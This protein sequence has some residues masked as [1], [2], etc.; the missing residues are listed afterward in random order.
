[1]LSDPLIPSYAVG[2]GNFPLVKVLPTKRV[3]QGSGTGGLNDTNISVAQFDTPKR[4]R[5]EVRFNWNVIRT[6]GGVATPVSLSAILA[7]D[8]PANGAF[9]ESEFVYAVHCI[10]D[11]VTDD[12]AKRIRVGEM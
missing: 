1:M 5:H 11:I 3:Y 10:K 4:K 8:E 9:T 7:V 12:I 6:I 2:Y